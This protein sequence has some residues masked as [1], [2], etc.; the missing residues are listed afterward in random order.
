MAGKFFGSLGK[1][2]VNIRAIAQGSSERNI[3]V[4][5][6]GRQATRAVAFSDL[7]N[8]DAL[9]EAHRRLKAIGIDKALARAG[10]RPGDT[11]HIGALEFE[12]EDG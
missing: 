3:S 8:A 2:G 5:V 10:A 9:D 1:A 12:Y 6:E 4:V 11:V 7:T